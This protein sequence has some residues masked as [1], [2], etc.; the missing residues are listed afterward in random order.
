ML[1]KTDIIGLLP[2]STFPKSRAEGLNT[3]FA[4]GALMVKC[5]TALRELILSFARIVC[6]PSLQ[7]VL[8][9]IVTSKILLPL[10]IMVILAGV[11]CPVSVAGREE[12]IE[13]VA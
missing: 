4:V 13:G 9:G 3:S 2:C 12:A 6:A 7:L 5:N 10:A 8:T 1:M 11:N